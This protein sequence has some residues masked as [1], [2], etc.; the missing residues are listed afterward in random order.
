MLDIQTDLW[1]GTAAAERRCVD[2]PHIRAESAFV[3]CSTAS[4][5]TGQQ[6]LKPIIAIHTT[7]GVAVVGET[8]L[9]LV[10]GI[11]MVVVPQN[12]CHAIQDAH[13]HRTK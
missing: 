10:E 6:V 8:Q 1:H 11:V 13:L 12:I 7:M 9:C 3:H 2:S 4:I 5:D